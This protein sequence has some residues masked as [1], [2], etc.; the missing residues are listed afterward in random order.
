MNNNIQ[1]ETHLHQALSE[2]GGIEVGSDKL[3]VKS[4]GAYCSEQNY[5]NICQDYTHW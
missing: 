2:I 1:E 4:H 3:Y 5:K